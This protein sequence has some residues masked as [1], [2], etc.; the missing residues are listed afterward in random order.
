MK[1][2]NY[3]NGRE[4]TLYNHRQGT[5]DQEQI[6]FKPRLVVK[7]ELAGGELPIAQ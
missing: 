5:F 2:K 7:R 3:R 6:A 1:S 4:Y